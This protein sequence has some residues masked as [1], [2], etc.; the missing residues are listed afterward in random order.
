MN[1]NRKCT[2]YEPTGFKYSSWDNERNQE[3]NKEKSFGNSDA[4]EWS[5]RR[6]EVV[7]GK[8]TGLI[9]DCSNDSDV[10]DKETSRY[11]K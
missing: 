8:R 5:K 3:K 6:S 11:I 1:A 10:S 2:I 9:I 7:S 4:G